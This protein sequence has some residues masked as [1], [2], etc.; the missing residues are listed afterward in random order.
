MKGIVRLRP[1]EADALRVRPYIILGLIC[2]TIFIVGLGS[3]PLMGQDEGL[4]AECSREM[5][6]G[7]NYIVPICNGE[8]FFDKPPLVYWLQAASI[9]VFGVNSF[10]ARFPSALSMIALVF[11]TAIAGNALYNRRAGF[12][13]GCVMAT[14][15]LA[16][17]IGRMAML[18]AA[19]TLTISISLGAFLLAYLERLPKWGYL[20]FWIAAGLSVLIKGPAA[21]VL[22]IAAVAA[23]LLIRRQFRLTGMGMLVIGFFLAAAIVLPW[24]VLVQRETGGAFLREFII[25][26]NLQR[27]LGKDFYH[28]QP[29]YFYLPILIFGFFPWSMFLPAV[30]TR[31]IRLRPKSA[32]E[33]TSLFLAIWAIAIIGIFSVLR[34]KL[35]SYILPAFPPA[36]LLVGV[37]WARAREPE[38]MTALRRAGAAAIFVG[39]L[40]SVGMQ[41][42]QKYLKDPIPGLSLPLAIMSGALFLGIAAAAVFL[43]RRCP[44]SAFI[45]FCAGMAG[46]LLAAV[47]VGL[48]IASHK[49]WNPVVDMSE[50]IRQW[51]YREE[52]VYSYR[53][54][55]PQPALGFYS[56][57]PV[58]PVS[59][60]AEMKK[61]LKKDGSALVVVQAER[62]NEI[63][64]HGTFL[65]RVGDYELYMYD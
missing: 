21:L 64:A 9:S 56:R 49:L 48:P 5:L 26:Q 46:F 24:Y 36:A 57:H 23:F 47:V 13:G 8:P 16:V 37:L 63:P 31:C 4:Y 11:L 19:L 14:S 28:N 60:V 38:V 12:L 27:A 22:I 18:D 17:G 58:T 2:A 45:S 41:I 35:P 15:L 10:A 3:V 65:G 33:E 62:L 6:A 1:G 25:H 53:L 54:S 59:T 42:G 40:L 30:W 50:Q 39:L 32:E 29:F 55:P 7:G 43:V 34:S 61:L 52:P 44:R 20:L 51:D